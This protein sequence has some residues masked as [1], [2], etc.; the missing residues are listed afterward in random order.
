L[1]NP[2]NA[3]DSIQ[4]ALQIGRLDFLS[5]I[6]A[7]MAFLGAIGIFP[8]FYYLRG[9]AASVARDEVNLALEGIE[10]TVEKLAV[11]KMEELLPT[12]IEEYGRF[13]VDTVSNEMADQIAQAQES[14]DILNENN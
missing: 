8:M 9:R 3:I 14:G 4:Y 11:S 13:A 10:N 6:L 1:E 5:A 7:V 12:L 2:G